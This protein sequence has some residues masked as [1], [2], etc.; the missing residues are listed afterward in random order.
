[1]RVRVENAMHPQ[2]MLIDQRGDI[3]RLATWIDNDGVII[4]VS[5]Q[6]TVFAPLAVHEGDHPETQRTP[7][8]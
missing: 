7:P 6:V 2:P 8:K 4:F 3:L 5:D 1:M